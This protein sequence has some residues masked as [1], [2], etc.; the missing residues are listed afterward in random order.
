MQDGMQTARLAAFGHS[1]CMFNRSG[2]YRIPGKSV[3]FVKY[4]EYERG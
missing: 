4:M 3:I 2:I 1:T